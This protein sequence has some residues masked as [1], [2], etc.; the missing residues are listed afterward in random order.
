[1]RKLSELDI[2]KVF[3]ENNAR[4]SLNDSR[5]YETLLKEKLI[6]LKDTNPSGVDNLID[7]YGLAD[8]KSAD[9]NLY[10]LFRKSRKIS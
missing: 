3:P 4:L 7:K 6:E 10:N 8:F 1:M 2:N 9:V 5:K